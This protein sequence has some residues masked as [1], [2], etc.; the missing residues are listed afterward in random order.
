VR[1]PATATRPVRLGKVLEFMGLLWAVDH[2]LESLSKRM[3]AA[4]GVTGPQRLALRIVGHSPGI[5]AG[6]LA[7]VLRV[8]PSTLTGVL[9]RLVRR[10]LVARRR[11]P[12]DARRALFELTARGRGV[13]ALRA[14]TVEAA[15]RRAVRRLPAARLSALEGMLR[16]VAQSLAREARRAPARPWGAPAGSA[17]RGSERSDDL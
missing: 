14:G 8:H 9:H 13:D 2:E 16:A 15:I 10:G 4:H 6:R 1:T 7:E 3:Y 17:R 5:A 11:D 12:A